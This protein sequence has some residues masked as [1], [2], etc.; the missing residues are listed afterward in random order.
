MSDLIAKVGGI[1]RRTM[2]LF[3]IVDT[4][5]SMEGSKIGAVNQAIR[6][7][8]PDIRDVSDNAD[9]KIKIAV[10]EFSFGA[11]WVTENGPVEAGQFNWNNLDAAGVTDFGAACRALADKLS[12]TKGFMQE[13]TGSFAPVLFLLSDGGPTDDWES[14]LKKLKE[15]K[16]YK[17][18]VKVALAIGADANED[19]AK[20]VL[21]EFTGSMEAVL[22]IHNSAALMKMIKFVSVR[23]SQVNTKPDAVDSGQDADNE[24][25]GAVEKLIQEVAAEPDNNE[26]DW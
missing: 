23:A 20:N 2:V 7:V 19:A 25:Q 3:F 12:A 15:N 17:V 14:G 11:H 8:I 18:A 1:P 16:W 21:K 10:L 26:P 5:G 9:A 4:S 22:E 24:K 6:E 13:A